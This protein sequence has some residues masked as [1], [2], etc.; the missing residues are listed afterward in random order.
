MPCPAGVD[1][2]QILNLVYEDRVLGFTENATK[3]YSGKAADC[4]KCGQ[5]EKKCTQSIKIIEEL[6]KAHKK[7]SKQA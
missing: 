1:I 4:T 3:R 6:Q 7:Y 2:P 5:C